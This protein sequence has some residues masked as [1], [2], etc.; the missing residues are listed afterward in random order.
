MSHRQG[1]P[2]VVKEE[3]AATVRASKGSAMDLREKVVKALAEQVAPA[4]RK[5]LAVRAVLKDRTVVARKR[6]CNRLC[7]WMRTAMEH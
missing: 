2:E 7:R 1:H 3:K 4:I 6:C 5:D